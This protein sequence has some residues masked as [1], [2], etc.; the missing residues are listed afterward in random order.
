MALRNITEFFKLKPSEALELAVSDDVIS[1]TTVE[2][3]E[4]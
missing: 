2:R 1:I 3:E 4:V